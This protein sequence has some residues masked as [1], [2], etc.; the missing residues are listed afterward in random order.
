MY[1]LIKNGRVVDPSTGTDET[2]DVLNA[3]WGTRYTTW[4]GL[5][6]NALPAPD[7]NYTLHITATD[8]YGLTGILGPGTAGGLALAACIAVT[9][10]QA[11]LELAR[12]QRFHRRRP[13]VQGLRPSWRVAL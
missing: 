3:A 7:G 5:D 13:R 2:L 11:E 10:A 1:R 9:S 8:T 6:D 12:H 4:D